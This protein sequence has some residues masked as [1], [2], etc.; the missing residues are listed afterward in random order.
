[1]ARY[2]RRIVGSHT[3]VCNFRSGTELILELMEVGSRQRTRLR[4]KELR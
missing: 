1:M 3:L 2:L 4:K